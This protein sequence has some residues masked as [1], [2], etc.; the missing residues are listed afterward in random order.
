MKQV[1]TK[2]STSPG[3]CLSCLNIAVEI[4]AGDVPS[5]WHT[6]ISRVRL[7]AIEYRVIRPAE[8]LMRIL[9]Y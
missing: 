8:A 4:P 1:P 2:R 3:A 5:T 9:R 7:D 6:L